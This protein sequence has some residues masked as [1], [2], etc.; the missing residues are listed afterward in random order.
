MVKGI[1]MVAAETIEKERENGPFRDFFEFTARILVRRISRANIEALIDAGALDCFGETRT[2]M[3]TGLDEA[4]SYAE[5]IRIEANGQTTIHPD[6]V[7]PPVLVRLHDEPYLIRENELNALGF[8]L[9]KDPI[10]DLRRQKNIRTWPLIRLAAFEG[11]AQGFARISN[12]RLHT[13]K[14]GEQMAFVRVSDE[15]ADLDLLFMPK[16]YRKYQFELKKGIYILFD[17][18]MEGNGKCIVNQM[19]IIS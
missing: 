4:I 17:G 10:I 14:R 9:G 1:G 6:L 16:T 11:N 7:S 18:K 19:T 12:F 5:L 3:K 15:T 2:T 8:T 13:T